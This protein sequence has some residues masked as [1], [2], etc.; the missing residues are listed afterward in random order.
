MYKHYKKSSSKKNSGNAVAEQESAPS[1]SRRKAQ[2][3]IVVTKPQQQQQQPPQQ[4]PPQTSTQPKQPSNKDI[5]AATTKDTTTPSPPTSQGDLTAAPDTNQPSSNSDSTAPATT[6]MPWL[7]THDRPAKKVRA[8]KIPN[9]PLPSRPLEPLPEQPDRPVSPSREAQQLAASTSRVLTA[10]TPKPATPPMA[11]ST[12]K[13]TTRP[14]SPEGAASPRPASPQESS[15]RAPPKKSETPETTPP[16]SQGASPRPA[17]PPPTSS[18]GE[19][20]KEDSADKGIV[21]APGFRLYLECTLN[22]VIRAL[23]MAPS[24]NMYVFIFS[25]FPFYLFTIS[26][27]RVAVGDQL[28]ILTLID[29]ETGECIFSHRLNDLGGDSIRSLVFTEAIIDEQD[30]EAW[31]QLYYGEKKTGKGDNDQISKEPLLFIGCESGCVS[32]LRLDNMDLK[33]CDRVERKPV[34]VILVAAVTAKGS[35]LTMP[36]PPWEETGVATDRKGDEVDEETENFVEIEGDSADTE[37]NNT[38]TNTTNEAKEKEKDAEAGKEK[39]KKTEHAEN[40]YNGETFLLVCMETCI[41]IYSI[42]YFEQLAR[43]DTPNPVVAAHLLCYKG[44]WCLVTFD[45]EIGIEIYTL[46]DLRHIMETDWNC[47]GPEMRLVVVVVVVV[48][49]NFPPLVSPK[50]ILAAT[51]ARDGR[52]IA[53]SDKSELHR[54]SFFLNENL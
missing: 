47:P 25:Y 46:T 49:I 23:A 14:A 52:L 13:V 15:P 53:P 32:M 6:D 17:S 29:T 41:G 16:S 26:L 39:K 43:V 28:G 27:K 30:Y 54:I 44:E 1:G 20:K 51:L 19:A 9:K 24:L 7:D 21:T 38:N 4:Q 11:S 36:S 42:P 37:G 31:Q 50:S 40:K 22:A 33:L 10:P 35:P 12:S 18:P 45:S 48:V 2:A 34:P 8:K 3:S 5:S